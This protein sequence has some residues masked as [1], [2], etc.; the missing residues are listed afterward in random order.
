[1]KRK[2]AMALIEARHGSYAH[3]PA[4]YM[5]ETDLL[6]MSGIEREP[7]RKTTRNLPTRKPKKRKGRN[8]KRRNTPNS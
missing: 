3:M 4:G 2:D 1:M 5:D 6:I 7:K 8:D